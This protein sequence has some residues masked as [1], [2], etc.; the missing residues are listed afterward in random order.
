MEFDVVSAYRIYEGAS[1]RRLGR[2]QG[3]SDISFSSEIFSLA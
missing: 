3:Y 1:G 2:A